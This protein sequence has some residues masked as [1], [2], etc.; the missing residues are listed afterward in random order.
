MINKMFEVLTGKDDLERVASKDDRA[1]LD[2]YLK[3][4]RILVPQEPTRF[5]DSLNSS[6]EEIIELMEKGV[7]D[8]AGDFR[9]WILDVDGEMRLPAFSS[10]KKVKLFQSKMSQYL[11][12]IFSLGL[13]EVLLVDLTNLYEID[14]VDLNRFSE[15][16]WEIR[17]R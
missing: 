10:L 15:K 16:N 11:D 17:L 13:G 3:S 14:V 7:S 8:I 6:D 4:R 12:K 2:E 1:L 9:P 5:L